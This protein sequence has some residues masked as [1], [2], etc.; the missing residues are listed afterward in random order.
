VIGQRNDDG[1]KKFSV[2]EDFFGLGRN[3]IASDAQLAA[4]R[5][6]LR[7]NVVSWYD[8]SNPLGVDA[9]RINF[10]TA[11]QRTL[12]FLP[13]RW[14]EK[15]SYLRVKLPNGAYTGNDPAV[16]G[17]IVYAGTSYIRN[18]TAGTVDPQHPDQVIGEMTG[19]PAK[20][21]YY[22][23]TYGW[24]SKSGLGS[25]A[26]VQVANDPNPPPSVFN[27]NAFQEC[28]VADSDWALYIAIE[29]LDGFP[30][31]NLAEVTDV[32][33]HIYFYYYNR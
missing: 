16:D 11:K 26:T 18:R 28:S 14:L 17:Y 10:S 2:R 21:L 29:D 22:D 25:Y 3:G 32:E 7:S 23:A 12:F 33:M 13:S 30:L 19:Y 1:Y 4:F 6:Y 9:V 15:I 31:V 20:Y 8:S 24:Q 5:A 27:I